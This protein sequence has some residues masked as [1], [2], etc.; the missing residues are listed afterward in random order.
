MLLLPL[1]VCWA[2][3]VNPCVDNPTT[4]PPQYTNGKLTGTLTVSLS[5][6][7]VCAEDQVTATASGVSAS[8]GKKTV[9]T[10]HTCPEFPPQTVVET[11]VPVTLTY[12]WTL[13]TGETQTTTT[14]TLTFYAKK[15]GSGPVSCTVSGEAADPNVGVDVGSGAVV[16]ASKNLTVITVEIV[17]DDSLLFLRNPGGGAAVQQTRGVYTAQV[18][19]TGG[20]FEWL[21][22]QGDLMIQ[23]DPTLQQVTVKTT[24]PNESAVLRVQYT[25]NGHSCKIFKNIT[26]RRPALMVHGPLTTTTAQVGQQLLSLS[27]GHF[28]WTLRD[29]KGAAIPGVLVT[30]TVIADHA[31]STPHFLVGNAQTIGPAVT[32]GA[33]QV[34]DI[35]FLTVNPQ[36]GLQES[37]DPVV[38]YNQILKAGG[39]RGNNRIQYHLPPTGITDTASVPL[40]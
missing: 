25:V 23:T 38:I 17:G 6:E 2:D 27:T 15:R 16:T 7:T 37:T 10:H 8:P 13:P 9:V 14:G 32:D 34:Q 22:F 11:A 29:Q 40:N 28:M 30:E 33:G 20:T 39:F 36:R 12:N 31:A 1:V 35:Y 3:N 24:G 19:P 18:D 4:D 21:V 5:E 26:I